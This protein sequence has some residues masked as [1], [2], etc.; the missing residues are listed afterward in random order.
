MIREHYS[1]IS[2]KHS[3]QEDRR[4]EWESIKLELR[5][6]TIP[7]AKNKAGHPRKKEED[8]QKRLRDLEPLISS[9][10]DS[11][12]LNNLETEYN[13][14]KQKL[15]H[16]YEHRG[17]DAIARS[18]ARWIEQGEKPTK[19]FFNLEKRNFNHKTVQAVKRSDGKSATNREDILE[20]IEIF[21]KNL[22]TSSV[23][24]ENMR[25]ENFI[26]N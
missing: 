22:Y 12:Q 1:F 6:L 20:E 14:L 16:I 15:C 17:K 7:Y 21:Y 3:G 8:L 23:V 25:F 11:A 9:G 13:E 19:Y 5:C 24:F 18:K 26:E 2:E 4:L 10:A